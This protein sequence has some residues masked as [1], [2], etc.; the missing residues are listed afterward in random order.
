MYFP[1]PARSYASYRTVN[2]APLRTPDAALSRAANSAYIYTQDV[3]SYRA[4]D[5]VALHPRAPL[6]GA[7]PSDDP[8]HLLP[9]RRP[10]YSSIT[11]PVLN[12]P[13]YYKSM[14]ALAKQEATKAAPALLLPP[15][16]ASVSSSGRSITASSGPSTGRLA[17]STELALSFPT[18]SRQRAKSQ[19]TIGDK[20]LR[21]QTVHRQTHQPLVHQAPATIYQHLMSKVVALIAAV[22]AAREDPRRSCGTQYGLSQLRTGYFAIRTPIQWRATL[23]RN[24]SYHISTSSTRA[25]SHKKVGLSPILLR[26]CS[27]W[28]LS[29]TV[30][31]R[32]DVER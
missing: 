23:H 4:A 10:S 12:S 9:S 1:F 32:S 13:S 3:A 17:S 2:P 8:N 6:L 31:A 7:P 5:Q 11:Q 14:E 29:A 21:H 25:K 26:S 18:D 20:M 22:A 28:R 24:R 15:H 27:M 16:V 30:T 19:Y